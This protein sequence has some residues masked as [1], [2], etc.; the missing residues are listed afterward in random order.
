MS[1]IPELNADQTARLVQAAVAVRERAYAPHSGF[2]VGSALLTEAD[3]IFVGCNVE[4]ASY[5][6]CICAERVAATSA[7]AAGSRA[8]RAIAVATEGG[9]TPCGA[10]RQFLSEFGMDLKVIMV[11][12]RNGATRSRTMSELLPDAFDATSLP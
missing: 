5:S 9:V 12:V 10:C 1:T 6:M 3:E 2:F 11:D 4:N 7:I 8:W